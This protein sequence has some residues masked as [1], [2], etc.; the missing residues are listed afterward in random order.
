[1][2]ISTVEKLIQS[3]G[4]NMLIYGKSGVGKTMLSATLPNPLLISAESGVLSLKKENLERIYGVGT[5]GICYNIPVVIVSTVQDL[6]NIHE[7]LTKSKDAAQFNS[8]VIDSLSE[9]GEVVLHHSKKQVKDPRQAYGELIDKMEMLI[10]S[11]RDLPKHVVMISKIDTLR[12]EFTGVT[13][14]AASMPGSKL[15]QKLPYFFDEVFR[16]GV[17]KTPQ[18]EVYRFLQTQPD[19]QFDAK[20]RSGCLDPVEYPNL[21]NIISKIQGA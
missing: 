15:G 2:Q 20:D 3:S 7:W 13:S 5:P 4:V 6:V 17:N 14:Y 21:S 1:M 19:L 9:I 12:D 18:G 10:R 11:F 16:L 8:V